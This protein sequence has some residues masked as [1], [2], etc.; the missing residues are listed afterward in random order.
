[1]GVEGT[2]GEP[3]R[4]TTAETADSPDFGTS[5]PTDAAPGAIAPSTVVDGDPA[6]LSVASVAEVVQQTESKI[7]EVE[8]QL[9]AAADLAP[10]EIPVEGD[11]SSST[12]VNVS[13]TIQASNNA[14]IDDDVTA[15]LRAAQR[16]GDTDAERSAK[17]D[18]LLNR[19][20]R[21][22]KRFEELAGRGAGA[23]KTPS[24]LLIVDDGRHALDLASLFMKSTR[25]FGSKNLYLHA[26]RLLENLSAFGEAVGAF[27]MNRSLAITNRRSSPRNRANAFEPVRVGGFIDLMA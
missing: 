18:D 25:L 6:P 7:A 27:N 13:N 23:E 4:R 11:Q 26:S 5:Q 8:Q 17:L 21:L 22:T 12:T 10:S 9:E 14:N 1:M 24:L 3:P 16:L 15:S 20:D 2:R 19:L